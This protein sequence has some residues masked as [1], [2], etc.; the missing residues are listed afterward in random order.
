MTKMFMSITIQLFGAPGG[1]I[2]SRDISAA[3]S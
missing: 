1:I 2:T 3:N